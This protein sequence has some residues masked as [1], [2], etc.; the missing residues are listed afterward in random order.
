MS[1]PLRLA[2]AALLLC[3]LAAQAELP[4]VTHDY[5]V[6]VTGSKDRK[7][8]ERL[9]ADVM[10]RWPAAVEL[11]EGYPKIES[12]DGKTGLNPGFQIAVAGV[13]SK[14]ADALAVRDAIRK[15]VPGAYVRKVARYLPG[16]FPECP[17][18]K[19]KPAAKEPTVP[20]GYTL[21]EQGP[22]KRGGLVWKIYSAPTADKRCGKHALVRLLDARGGL[23]D[24]RQEEA[25]CV[26]GD[27]EVDGSG[28]SKSWSASLSTNGSADYVMLTYEQWAS[29]TG[30]NGGS[31]LCATADG[32]VEEGLDGEC[33]SSPYREGED[34][35]H[36]V[37]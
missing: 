14:E 30:C 36:C 3:P 15:A 27:P 26:E 25:Q 4:V 28:E 7:Q 34:E 2:L 32:I 18:L 33:N 24:E 16:F 21:T 19:V 17:R 13:C 35:K 10:K 22:A 11:G 1:H 37:E 20:K 12:S 6:I 8:T 9:L 31:A 5:F 23:V 29:D